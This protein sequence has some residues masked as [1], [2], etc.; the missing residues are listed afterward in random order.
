VAEPLFELLF[1]LLSC[2]GPGDA[3]SLTGETVVSPFS[4]SGLLFHGCQWEAGLRKRTF[5]DI[6]SVT[7]LRCARRQRVQRQDHMYLGCRGAKC[8]QVQSR[9]AESAIWLGLSTK[10]RGE[11]A[12]LTKSIVHSCSIN[13][14]KVLVSLGGPVHR[15]L[16]M[17]PGLGPANG[18]LEYQARLPNPNLD[19]H[20][21]IKSPVPLKS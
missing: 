4:R 2:V 1:P 9:D 18:P 15:I 17:Y 10:R 19:P 6:L 16:R 14:S 21:E 12:D 7:T 5:L 8:G 13:H 11:E 3:T 20:A